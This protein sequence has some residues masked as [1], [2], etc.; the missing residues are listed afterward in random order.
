MKGS[1]PVEQVKKEFGKYLDKVIFMPVINLDKANAQQ[2][3]EDYMKK[4]SSA[5]F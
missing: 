3:I 5:C 2:M 1:Q 4:I